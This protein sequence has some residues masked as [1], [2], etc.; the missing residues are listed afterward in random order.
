MEVI[1]DRPRFILE[2]KEAI[3]LRLLIARTT[4]EQRLQFRDNSNFP[5]RYKVL[6][7]KFLRDCGDLYEQLIEALGE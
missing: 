4:P 5:G 6:D 3:L 7:D 1:Y 2:E